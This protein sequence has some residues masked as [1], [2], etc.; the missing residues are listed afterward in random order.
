MQLKFSLTSKKTYTMH[1][2]KYYAAIKNVLVHVHI[3]CT[4]YKKIDGTIYH[5]VN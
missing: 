4:M 5:R 2:V 1:T 3:S